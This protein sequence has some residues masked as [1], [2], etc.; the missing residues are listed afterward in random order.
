[1]VPSLYLRFARGWRRYASIHEAQG[2][3]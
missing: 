2:A 3:V 1:V